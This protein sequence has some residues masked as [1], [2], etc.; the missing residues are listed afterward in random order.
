LSKSKNLLLVAQKQ[1]LELPLDIRFAVGPSNCIL[2]QLSGISQVQLFLDMS[3]V[4]F[5]RF[6]AEMQSSG[7]FACAVT[8]ADHS[9]DF[10]FSVA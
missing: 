8:L 10:E 1:L 4:C 5:N 2:E 9:E 6:Y 3:S 7:D